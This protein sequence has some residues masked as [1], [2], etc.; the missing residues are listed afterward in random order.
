MVPNTQN[1]RYISLKRVSDSTDSD[2][3][4]RRIINLATF[5]VWVDIDGFLTRVPPY[6]ITASPRLMDL[7]VWDKANVLDDN[8]DT[9]YHTELNITNPFITLDMGIVRKIARVL[10]IPRIGY[11]NR[12]IGLQLQLADASANIVYARD[13]TTAQDIYEITFNGPTNI[14][15]TPLLK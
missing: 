1:A 13:L 4:S 15:S 12:M 9:A 3:S 5:A 8:S 11:R 2:P 14:P 6:M 10:L 7:A